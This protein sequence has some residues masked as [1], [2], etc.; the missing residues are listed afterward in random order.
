MF[1]SSKDSSV[2]LLLL[3][4]VP[5]AYKRPV[6]PSCGDVV[7]VLTTS[8]NRHHLQTTL[9]C[10]CKAKPNSNNNNHCCYY[11]TDCS[12]Q[13]NSTLLP[14][15]L[16]AATTTTPQDTTTALQDIVDNV[17]KARPFSNYRLWQKLRQKRACKSLVTC[18]DVQPVYRSFADILEGKFG[19]DFATNET[20]T[21]TATT[22]TTDCSSDDACR[23][24][25][26]W[27]QYAVEATP[28]FA[29][30]I[31]EWWLKREYG[32]RFLSRL[33]DE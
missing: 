9:L 29:P 10:P 27:I 3:Q 12:H 13:H 28:E 17:K 21:T 22:T 32:G 25:V 11:P 1:G 31:Y 24:S 18:T 15:T 16:M 6:C 7:G 23:S 19:C 5:S 8:P 30:T 26:E 14:P 33:F 20:T 2:P 4:H